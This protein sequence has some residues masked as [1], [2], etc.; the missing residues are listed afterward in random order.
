M[1]AARAANALPLPWRRP[2]DANLRVR[3]AVGESRVD[4]MLEGRDTRLEPVEGDADI[5]ITTDS[6]SLV[7]A[8]AR[9]AARCGDQWLTRREETS[10]SRCSPYTILSRLSVA[11]LDH[12]LD[13]VL[14]AQQHAGVGEDPE[15]VGQHRVQDQLPDIVGIHRFEHRTQIDLPLGSSLPPLTGRCDTVL[16]PAAVDAVGPMP[17][18]TAP[19]QSTDVR[20]GEWAARNSRSSVAISATTPCLATL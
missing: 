5:V 11:V 17:V 12:R 1:S 4:I 14:H 7:R 18:L 10:S 13:L 8:A 9:R 3:L 2:I 6:A 19:G 16:G 15:P 20:T